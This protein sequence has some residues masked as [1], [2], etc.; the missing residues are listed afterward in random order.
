MGRKPK[1]VGVIGGFKVNPELLKLAENEV[2]VTF[3]EHPGLEAEV[4]GRVSELIE[5]PGGRQVIESEDALKYLKRN[6]GAELAAIMCSV[7]EDNFKAFTKANSTARPTAI[8]RRN[9]A[10]AYVIVDILLSQIPNDAAVMWL[11]G[12]SDYL[13]GI[14]AV[15]IHRR[16]ED[17]RMAA[18][19]R[20]MGGEDVYIS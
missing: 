17:V 15:E 20:V 18:L 7:S 8:Q 10:A 4:K 14:P 13:Y 9:I 5:S 19:N 3:A 2:A 6:L 1:V 16:P 11:T 12:Y